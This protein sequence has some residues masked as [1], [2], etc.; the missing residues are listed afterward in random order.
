MNIQILIVFFR[1]VMFAV[2]RICQTS[3]ISLIT[4]SLILTTC[5]FHEVVSLFGE[6]SLWSLLWLTGFGF[7]IF[8]DLFLFRERMCWQNLWKK[9]A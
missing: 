7:V 2:E 6:I 4:T 5:M 1:C 8:T 3:V 9:W